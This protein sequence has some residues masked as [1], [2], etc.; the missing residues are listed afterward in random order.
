V[1]HNIDTVDL[2]EIFKEQADWRRRKAAEYPDD[3]RNLEAANCFDRLAA[4]AGDVPPAVMRAYA[5]LFEDC[6][7][8]E[9]HAELLKQ[10]GFQWLPDDASEFVAA[11]IAEQTT[12]T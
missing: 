11:F 3:V 5:E 12:T 10:V 4:T 9:R 8:A 1:H 2:A 7:D 6:H